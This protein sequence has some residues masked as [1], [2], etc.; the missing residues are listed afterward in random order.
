MSDPVQRRAPY[1]LDRHV[2]QGRGDRVAVRC[3]GTTTTYAQLRDLAAAF[4]R[5]L[6]ELG[7]RTGERVL[8]VCSDRTELLAGLLGA[9][10][11]GAV[12]VPVSTMLTGPELA[13]LVVDSG[14]RVLVV[15][16]EF[17]AAVAAAVRDAPSSRTS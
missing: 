2:E 10:R 9:M 16:P 7:T 15:S 1:F 12:A 17:P 13:K 8:F 4:A 6:R 11:T 3:P 5:G 14:A